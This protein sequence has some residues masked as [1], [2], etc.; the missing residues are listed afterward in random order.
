V[1]WGGRERELSAEEILLF[2]K[3]EDL[4]IE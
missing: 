1:D 4:D 2:L 3:E